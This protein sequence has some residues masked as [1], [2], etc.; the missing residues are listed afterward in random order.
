MLRRTSLVALIAVTCTG[1]SCQITVPDDG[2]GPGYIQLDRVTG[3]IT[4]TAAMPDTS[5]V[6]TASLRRNGLPVVLHDGQEITINGSPL[7]GPSLNGLYTV[8]VPRAAAYVI[9]VVEPT[10]GTN[11]TTVQAPADFSIST[12]AAGETVSL[13][14]GFDLTWTHATPEV[15][16]VAVLTQVLTSL[17]VETLGPFPDDPAFRQITATDLMK[18]RQGANMTIKLSKTAQVNGIGGLAGGSV[19]VE[20]SQSTSVVPGP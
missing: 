19:R 11:E 6:V 9:R 1:V 14:G 10:L 12:P 15:T 13:S 8:T 2:T 18:F 5:A 4:I 7:Q 20:L 17:A 3:D 16:T